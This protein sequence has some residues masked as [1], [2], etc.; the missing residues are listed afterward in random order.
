MGL[1][2]VEISRMV[3]LIADRKTGY[4]MTEQKE[5]STFSKEQEDKINRVAE[6]R[7]KERAEAKR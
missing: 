4:K 2:P 6:Q 3:D 1:T 5:L 7:L